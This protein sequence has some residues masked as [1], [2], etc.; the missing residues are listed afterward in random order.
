MNE[1]GFEY[2]GR[3]T[4]EYIKF[5]KIY[6]HFICALKKI[7]KSYWNYFVDFYY[8]SINVIY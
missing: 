6:F 8:F 2:L 4:S 1:I 3:N 7:R 5:N